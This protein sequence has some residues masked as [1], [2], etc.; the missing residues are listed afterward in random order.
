MRKTL[1]ALTLAAGL[2]YG[3]A[4]VVAHP[5]V[6]I[7]SWS[8]V[9]FNDAGRI[10]AIYVEWAFDQNYSELAIEGL[11]ANNDGHYSAAELD[12][13]TRENIVALKDYNY[14][15]YAKADGKQLKYEDVTEYNQTLSGKILKMH[16]KVPLA[17]PVDPKA[18]SFAYKIYDPSFYIAIDYSAK[19]PVNTIGTVP[20]GCAVEL[21]KVVADEQTEETRQMLSTK[22]Q[23]WQPDEN[24]DFGA[25]FAQPVFVKCKPKTT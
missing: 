11:D 4:P 19:S 8:D 17:E 18:V 20:K 25:M 6:V 14:F 7:E 12:V 9:V 15:V 3:A 10:E 23:D 13:L 1:P 24:E 2:L 5:H 21:G 22:D 16:F